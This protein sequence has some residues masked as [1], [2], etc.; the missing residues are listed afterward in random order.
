MLILIKALTACAMPL[1]FSV[2]LLIASVIFSL[3]N[4]K[5]LSLGALVISAFWLIAF[6][7]PYIANQVGR[8]LEARYPAIAPEL[9]VQTYPRIPIIVVLGGGI[10]GATTSTYRPWPDLGEPS[11]RVWY[12]SRLFKAYQKNG[13]YLPKV[14]LSGGNI[15]PR[16]SISSYFLMEAISPTH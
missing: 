10:R 8:S 7:T 5:Y 9:V 6:S 14:L 2:L 12:A 1:G 16:F 3:R 15:E 4:K 13:T 11:D